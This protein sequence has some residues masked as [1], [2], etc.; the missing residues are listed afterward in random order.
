MPARIAQARREKAVWEHRDIAGADMARE[1]GVAPETV[2]SWEA[3][4]T[5]PRAAGLQALATYLGVTVPW[6][7]YRA[8]EQFA[9]PEETLELPDARSGTAGA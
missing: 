2:R 7:R 8:G 5:K 3:G 1:I 6:L 9:A 4:E